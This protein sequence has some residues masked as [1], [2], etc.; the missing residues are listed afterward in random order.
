MQRRRTSKARA[1]EQKFSESKAAQ[2][3]GEIRSGSWPPPSPELSSEQ[4]EGKMVAG[5]KRD[6]REDVRAKGEAG[7]SVV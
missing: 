1:R 4:V 2:G 5:C 6:E 3:R 7:C